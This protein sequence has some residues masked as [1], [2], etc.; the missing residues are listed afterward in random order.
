[1]KSIWLLGACVPTLISAF[2]TSA[3]VAQEGDGEIIVT[4]RRREET[5]INV[6]VAVSAVTGAELERRGVNSLDGIARLV[7]QLISA[8]GGTVTGGNIV[9]R[10]IGGGDNPFGDQA[11]SFNIDGVQIARAAIRR[12]GQM[13]M[14]QVEV[15][16]GPQALFYGKNSP[17]G[18]ISIRTGDP[19]KQLTG[20]A[21]LGYEVN[22]D[23]WRGEA[24]IAGP[25][26]DDLGFRVAAY[27]SKMRGWVRNTTPRTEIAAPKHQY[28]PRVEEF[29]VR[30]TLKYEPADNFDARLKV[31]YGEVHSDGFTSTLQYVFCGNGTPQHGQ[32]DDCKANDT[33]SVGALR[34]NF[35]GR[36]P[37]FGKANGELYG[38]QKQALIGLEMNYH[39]SDVLT[40]SSITGFYSSSEDSLVNSTATYVPSRVLA[41][42][43]KLKFTELS[44][45]LRVT[46][47]FDG[48]LNFMFGT[49]LQDSKAK[50]STLAVFNGSSFNTVPPLTPL[51]VADYALKQ[52]GRAY[53]AFMQ[54]Q[55]DITDQIQLSS[56][57]R[58]SYE[59]KKLPLVAIQRNVDP[60]TGLVLPVEPFATPVTKAKWNDF[61]PEVT[62]SYHPD[63]NTNIYGSY[64]HGFISGGFNSGSSG[65]ANALDY[66]QQT[67]KGFEGG[68]KAS[69]FSGTLRP[70]LALYTYSVTGLQVTV[71]TQGTIQE[72]KNVGKVRSKGGEFD[73]VY[74]TPLPGL[75]LSSAIAYNRARY[76]EYFANCYRG[77]S[78]ARGCAFV[79]V[80]GQVGKGTPAPA[81][82]NGTLQNLAGTQVLRAPE[83]TGNV[84]FDYESSIGTNLKIGLSANMSFSASYFADPA[85]NPNGRVPSYQLFDATLRIAQADDRWEVA[86]IGRNLTD[87]FYWGRIVDSPFTGTAP[88]NE[89]GPSVY[90][91]LQGPVSRGRE[92]MLRLSTK[93]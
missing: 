22:A 35:A 4:A 31:N 80:A 92:V 38:L 79:P 78:K 43:P 56:G 25:I 69:L 75:T 45:E 73:L 68:V 84:G 54:M 37:I 6:P 64:K 15:L 32:I 50:T 81:G 62:L 3:A 23:E 8:D 70:S 40:L 51:I 60:A 82:V 39:P 12:M 24:F 49:H 87:Q 67:V 59:R 58:Y 55:W 13:D 85:S 7:P 36:D 93:F 57:G 21:S 17:G 53:S 48:P 26:T 72:L 63:R 83:W 20:K 91:D 71:V 86:L 77:Q 16:K 29:A 19:T 11:V 76:V 74:R 1:M 41:I 42:H 10:G 88:G 27:G 28:A 47:N 46:S 61:S 14:Q 65:F 18:V 90:G 52:E 5:L 66:D 44:E 89:T 33:V 30:G 34:P 9:L 2:Y